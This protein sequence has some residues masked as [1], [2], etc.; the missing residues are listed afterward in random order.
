MRPPPHPCKG[1]MA[2][3]IAPALLSLALLAPVTSAWAQEP[4]PLTG[5]FYYAV[6]NLDAGRIEQRGTAGSG[7]VAFTNLRLNPRTRYRF[8]LLE[9]STLRIGRVT[10]TTPDNGRNFQI[11]PIAV[12]EPAS[13]DDDGDQLSLQGER[14]LGT[15]PR[16][17]DSDGDRI[18]DGVEVRQGTD[19]LDGLP[20]RTGIVATLDTPGT[21]LDVCASDD[22][23]VVADGLAGI[24]VFN[25]FN[26]LNPQVIAR[27]E[28]PGTA[29]RV[30]CEG[31]RVAVASNLGVS[32]VDLSDPPAARVLYTL[33]RFL[34]GGEPTGVAVV[35]RVCFVSL[36]TKGAVAFDLVTGG[37]LER[38]FLPEATHDVRVERDG[39]FFHTTSGV[40]PLWL[41]GP[42]GPVATPSVANPAVGR[43]GR[44]FV[45]GGEA[46]SA[47]L[48]GL[49]R[50][51]FRDL[52]APTRTSLTN[53]TLVLWEQQVANGSGLGVAIT[54]L[55]S[56]APR[57]VS[58]FDIRSPA[59]PGGFVTT[60][61]TPGSAQ[62]TTA[63]PTSQ[64]ATEAC[65]SSTTSP[66]T[67]PESRQ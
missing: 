43:V 36:A 61:R 14:I 38:F 55:T 51:D 59:Q 49:A 17:P 12:S 19:P 48:T 2:K 50:M 67:P 63:W 37:V 62:A 34:L 29:R 22:Y 26:R 28:I 57:D 11:P 39:V 24:S 9:A 33:D 30:S 46:H 3:K 31:A 44:L 25:V 16:N 8:W 54:Q 65:R 10:V 35:D 5:L 1:P 13:F 56:V 32:V 40:Q 66:T 42:T 21:A 47:K 41:R 53:D 58:L 15:D 7:G 6:E 60:W 64:T 52:S 27:V 4:E 45:G 20:G 23:V 18:P